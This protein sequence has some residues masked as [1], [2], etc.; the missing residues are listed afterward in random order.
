MKSAMIAK[1]VSALGGVPK[2]VGTKCSYEEVFEDFEVVGSSGDDRIDHVE[3]PIGTRFGQFARHSSQLKMKHKMEVSDFL[4]TLTTKDLID[5][6]GELEDYFELE[7]IEDLL[8]VRLAQTK[9]KG[10]DSLWWK[11]LQREK[12]ED[13]EVKISR[14]RLMVTKLKVK[15]I[16]TDYELDFFKTLQNMKL[17]DSQSNYLFTL[18]N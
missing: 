2:H 6:I 7:D 9:L 5:W 13:S 10:H 3:R 16:P 11:E 14:W 8:K 4:G 17:K 1:I 18:I 15:F 12:E